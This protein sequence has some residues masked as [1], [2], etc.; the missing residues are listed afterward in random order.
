MIPH[1]RNAMIQDDEGSGREH[2]TSGSVRSM[3]RTSEGM[4]VHLSDA[5]GVRIAD[6]QPD[7]RGWEVRG[8][9]GGIVGT[10]ADLLIDPS[11]MRVRYV[12]V[13]LD[14]EAAK[15]AA[16]IRGATVSRIAPSRYALVPI[17][18]ARADEA[19]DRLYLAAGAGQLFEL[20]PYDPSHLTRDYERR[21]LRCYELPAR[22]DARSGGDSIV[23]QADE[24]DLFYA[25]PHFDE[26]A[27]VGRRRRAGDSTS[28]V[29]V[30][31]TF[32]ERRAEA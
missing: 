4:L 13:T 32:T 5:D 14:E 25:E 21:L 1:E 26:R 6:G 10:V 16:R 28:Y 17:G 18:L 7:V 20:P 12:E 22:I 8:P 30:D 29:T 24:R 9:R 23:E 3:R 19:H 31:S 15:E 2:V 11:A 27:F